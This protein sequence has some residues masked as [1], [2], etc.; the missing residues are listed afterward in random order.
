MQIVLSIYLAIRAQAGRCLSTAPIGNNLHI[1]VKIGAESARAGTRKRI[2][3][4]GW[5]LI[6]IGKPPTAQ[7]PALCR[8]L[9]REGPRAR[10]S[11]GVKSLIPPLKFHL[12]GES[13]RPKFDINFL[14]LFPQP[15]PSFFRAGARENSMVFFTSCSSH[16]P[17]SCPSGYLSRSPPSRLYRA[18]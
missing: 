12:V 11:I 14:P 6:K 15:S 10:S 8:R 7:P 4:T 13:D 5:K 18:R 3:F 1:I 16:F 17:S 2:L 9:Q